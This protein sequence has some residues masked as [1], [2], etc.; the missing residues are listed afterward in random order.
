MNLMRYAVMAGAILALLAPATGWAAE[1]VIATAVY[2]RVGNGYKREKAKDGSF[3]PE[4]YALSNGGRLDGT[5]A[6]ITVDRVTYPEVAELTQR[7]LTRQ[8]YHY[9]RDKEEATLLLVLNWGNTIPFDRTAYEQVVNDVGSGREG[10]KGLDM[11]NLERDQINEDNAR[12]LGYMDDLAD[13]NDIRRWAGG[14]D[15]YKDLIADVEEGRYYVMISA[16][17]FKAL[18]KWGKRQLLWQVRVSVRSPGNN[19]VDSLVP[20]LRSASKYFGQDSGKLVRIEES[21]GTVELG[22]LKFLGE[23]GERKKSSTQE[24]K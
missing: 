22:D 20:L 21:K 8:N 4:Y 5:T 23:A 14:G 2:S 19:F 7:F 6:D 18:S 12:I 3:Q 15:R 9:A 24:D 16:Y 13:S 17:D 1:E 10:G 11:A